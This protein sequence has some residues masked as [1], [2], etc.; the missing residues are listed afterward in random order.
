MAT[1][2][3][4]SNKPD[5]GSNSF[6]IRYV[7]QLARLDLTDE[8]AERYGAQLSKVLA[9]AEKLASLDV[10]EIEPTAHAGAVFAH[11]VEDAARPGFS[12]DQALANAPQQNAD[13]FVVPKVVES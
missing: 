3:P 8:E 6:D 9:Y 5:T 12:P 10:S 7:A 13:Q 1:T 11:H 2:D 4:S